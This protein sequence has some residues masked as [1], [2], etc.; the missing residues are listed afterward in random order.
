MV[1]QRLFSVKFMARYLG[2]TQSALYQMLYRDAIPGDCIV[3]MGKKIHF[4]IE[5]V[6]RW[7]DGLK[8]HTYCVTSVVKETQKGGDTQWP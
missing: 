2:M 5:A 3:R 4:D 7:I 1:E 8:G 6:D